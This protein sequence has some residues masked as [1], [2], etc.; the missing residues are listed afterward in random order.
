MKN[1]AVFFNFISL[2]IMA[3]TVLPRR[4][5]K[6]DDLFLLI[7]FAGANIFAL[8]YILFSNQ[9][10]GNGSSLISLWLQRKKLEEQQKIEWACRSHAYGGSL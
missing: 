7:V 3:C 8:I 10:N 5:P 1:L 4:F 6:G 9:G 2:V